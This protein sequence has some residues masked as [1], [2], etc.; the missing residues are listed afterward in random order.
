MSN[1]NITLISFELSILQNITRNYPTISNLIKTNNKGTL[2]FLKANRAL[3]PYH[4]I[5]DFNVQEDG[6]NNYKTWEEYLSAIKSYLELLCSKV[7]KFK[8][9]LRNVRETLSQEIH[10]KHYLKFPNWP[11]IGEIQKSRVELGVADNYE[12]FP[13]TIIWACVGWINVQDSHPSEFEF[14]ASFTDKPDL[15]I[16]AFDNIKLKEIETLFY[17]DPNKALEKISKHKELTW[18]QLN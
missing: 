8:E 5:H 16:L 4:L 10:D 11:E 14:I 13:Y 15:K 3:Y 2:A 12:S 18:E 7:M 17:Q 6:N 1:S 9:H